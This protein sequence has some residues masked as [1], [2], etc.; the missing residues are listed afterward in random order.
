MT[1]HN[2][3]SEQFNRCMTQDD[4]PWLLNYIFRLRIDVSQTMHSDDVTSVVLEQNKIGLK[5]IE[6]VVGIGKITLNRTYE[7]G[8]PTR[9]DTTIFP[10]IKN[11]KGFIE[12]L[13]F[14]RD[15]MT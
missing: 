7:K 12:A 2:R 13:E 9:E 14:N 8:S 4:I 11:A 5:I 3:Y 10:N 1:H 15:Q 6:V